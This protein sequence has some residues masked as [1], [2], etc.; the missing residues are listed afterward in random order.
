MINKSPIVIP[1]SLKFIVKNNFPQYTLLLNKL[2]IFHI[3]EKKNTLRKYKNNIKKMKLKVFKTYKK[4]RA[5]LFNGFQ[6][7]V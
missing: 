1:L 2:V 7:K 6:K 5:I 4:Y 3:N